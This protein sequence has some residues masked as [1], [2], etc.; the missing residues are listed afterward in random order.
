[1]QPDEASE[2]V[3]PA[4]PSNLFSDI[5]RTGQ[6]ADRACRTGRRR[7]NIR[8]CYGTMCPRPHIRASRKSVRFR[9][10]RHRAALRAR[11]N[12]LSPRRPCR[13]QAT[14]AGLKIN[15]AGAYACPGTSVCGSRSCFADNH[16]IRWRQ[17]RPA[18]HIPAYAAMHPAPVTGLPTARRQRE[19]LHGSL[20]CI[21]VLREN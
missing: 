4:R 3:T 5:C 9:R 19:R 20:V 18:L 11:G 10:H 8:L 16:R 1:M 2:P 14:E 6:F 17:V 21:K 7:R 12:Q 15:S 13:H